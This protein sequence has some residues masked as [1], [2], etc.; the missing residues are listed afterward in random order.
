[1]GVEGAPNISD[2][3]MYLFVWPVKLEEWEARI[4]NIVGSD[5][6]VFSID[7]QV[8]VSFFVHHDA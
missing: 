8:E 6:L 4:G 5:S 7:V 2:I 3:Q 1:M